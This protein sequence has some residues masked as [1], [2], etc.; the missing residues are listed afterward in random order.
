MSSLVDLLSPADPGYKIFVA[1][2]YVILARVCP[3]LTLPL[4]F[5]SGRGEGD[6]RERVGWVPWLARASDRIG[7]QA[8]IWRP[9]RVKRDRN[10]RCGRPE[11]S[12]ELKRLGAAA[13]LSLRSGRQEPLRRAAAHENDKPGIVQDQNRHYDLQ[14]SIIGEIC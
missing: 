14:D 2:A 5:S 11:S 12:K 6:W 13:V 9:C 7:S 10:G 8:R 4:P 1:V 3:R